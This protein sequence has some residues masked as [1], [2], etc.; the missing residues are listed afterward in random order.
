MAVDFAWPYVG[1]PRILSRKIAT[2]PSPQEII[3][4]RPSIT[5]SISRQLRLLSPDS[6]EDPPYLDR[7]R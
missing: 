5:A 3:D 7:F 6:N 2:L 4:I 1:M